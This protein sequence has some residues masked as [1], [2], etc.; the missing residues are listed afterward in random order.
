MGTQEKVWYITGAS[1]GLGLSLVKQLLA[2]GYKVAAT[3]EN[4][5][6]LENAVGA[7]NTD[8]LPMAVVPGDDNS[9]KQSIETTLQRFGKIDVVVNNA[10]YGLLGSVEELSDLES[11]AN[12]EVNFFGMLNVIRN[13]MPH[14]RKQ[15]SGHIFNISS[16]G[17]FYGG[18]PGFGIYCATKF[19][20][21]GLSESLAVEARSFG[22]HVTVVLPGYSS[23]DFLTSDSLI[24]PESRIP[25]YADVRRSQEAHLKE[26]YENQDLCRERAVNAIITVA[27]AEYPPLNLFLGQDAYGM[28]DRKITE[29]QNN[30]DLW[31]NLAV[32]VEA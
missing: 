18:S 12:F 16:I 25:D 22:V 13:T 31:E 29:I 10:G 19:A 24:V 32:A 14:F 7:D 2:V 26:I 6:A 30:M 8:F 20:V 5:I 23:T 28:A 21:A 9:V 27:N 11:R 15:R 3:S 4:L 17:G 1:E